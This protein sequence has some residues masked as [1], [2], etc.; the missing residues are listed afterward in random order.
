VEGEEEGEEAGEEEE[1][2]EKNDR[3][4]LG[5]GGETAGETMSTETERPD[6]VLWSMF[7][8]ASSSPTLVPW[9]PPS[10]PLA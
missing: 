1:E 4:G 10:R 7:L 2:K 5:E 8:C 3:L 6:D 9:A